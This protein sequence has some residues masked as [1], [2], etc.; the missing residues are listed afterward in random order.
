MPCSGLVLTAYANLVQEEGAAA[1]APAPSKAAKPSAMIQRLKEQLEAQKRAEEE[2]K[3][4]EEERLRRIEE[5]RRLEEE[6]VRRGP[7]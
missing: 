2:F 4:Q 1:A 7:R 3:R 6:E 5:E